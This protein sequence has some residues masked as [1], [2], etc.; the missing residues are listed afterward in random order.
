M[1]DRSSSTISRAVSHGVDSR[2]AAQDKIYLAVELLKS[3][4]GASEAEAFV[5]LVQASTE[6]QMS[7]SEIAGLLADESAVPLQTR[8]RAARIVRQRR[9]E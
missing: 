4:H 8:R 7:V 3:Q 2:R 5:M 9:R 6:R 1:G